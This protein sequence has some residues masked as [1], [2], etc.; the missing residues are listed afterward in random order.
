MISPPAAVEISCVKCKVKTASRN[1][2]AFTTKDERPATRSTRKEWDTRKFTIG[3]LP[4]S[5]SHSI[6]IAPG[7]GLTTHPSA[8]RHGRRG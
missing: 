4:Q 1:N 7:L 2:E 5:V 8:A 3:V 6:I